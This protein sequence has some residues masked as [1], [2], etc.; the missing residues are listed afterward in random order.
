MANT[1]KRKNTKKIGSGHV[2]QNV[3]PKWARM[4]LFNV[5]QLLPQKKMMI[6]AMMMMVVYTCPL[7]CQEEHF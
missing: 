5:S 6:M 4:L 1:P 3:S 7:D 2:I